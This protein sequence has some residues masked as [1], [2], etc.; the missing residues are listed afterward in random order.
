MAQNDPLWCRKK[1]QLS[2]SLSALLSC[3]VQ[4]PTTRGTVVYKAPQSL[5]FSRQEYW[6]G[7]LFPPLGNLLNSGIKPTSLALAG[8][9]FATEPPRKPF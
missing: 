6:S 5:G 4:L 8:R 7:L 2:H 1:L 3:P 9:F